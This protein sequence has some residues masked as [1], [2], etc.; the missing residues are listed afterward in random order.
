VSR[1]KHGLVDH[2]CGLLSVQ[3]RRHRGR[4]RP[5]LF[6]TDRGRDPAGR[7]DKGTQKARLEAEIS[8]KELVAEMVSEDLKEAEKDQLCKREGF[9]VMRYH[10]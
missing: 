2:L 1:K 8:F 6:P 5:A 7:C 9:K 10:E 4:G 3:K